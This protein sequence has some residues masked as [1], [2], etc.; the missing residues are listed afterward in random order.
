MN[1]STGPL[2]NPADLYQRHQEYLNELEKALPRK[3]LECVVTAICHPDSGAPDSDALAVTHMIGGDPRLVAKV[4]MDMVHHL[5]QA[6]PAFKTAFLVETVKH[7]QETRRQAATSRTEKNE[8]ATPEEIAQL[9]KL[10]GRELEISEE[11]KERLKTFTLTNNPD[12]GSL[13]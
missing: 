12:K 4:I 11:V 8:G 7:L 1:E 5:M 9:S 13:H 2:D 6:D 3:E 10:D